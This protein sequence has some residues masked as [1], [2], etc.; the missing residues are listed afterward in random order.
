MNIVVPVMYL[1]YYLE[2]SEHHPKNALHQQQIEELRPRIREHAEFFIESA[3][4]GTMSSTMATTSYDEC[5]EVDFVL[6][7]NSGTAQL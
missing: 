7:N 6:Y 4:Q 1:D 3:L 2:Q 5:L